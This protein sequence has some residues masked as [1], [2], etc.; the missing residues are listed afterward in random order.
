MDERDWLAERFEEHRTHLRAVAYRILGSLSEADD[1]VQDAWLR[2]SRSDISDV[3]NLPAWLTTVVARVSL[4][5]LSARQ[6]RREE[7]AGAH[8]PQPAAGR[9]DAADPEHQEGPCGLRWPCAARGPRHAGPRRAARV[10]AARHVRHLV[11]PDRPHHRALAG[12]RAP[13][14][15]PRPPPG[16]GS[17]R[18]ARH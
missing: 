12:G 17:G 11:R 1:A 9:E 7:L 10:R 6:S 5:M 4:N 8:L 2:L 18:G 3:E 14:R 13:T 16:P 15:E